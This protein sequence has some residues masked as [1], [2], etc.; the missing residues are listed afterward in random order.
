VER[1][2]SSNKEVVDIAIASVN[3]KFHFSEK[4]KKRKSERGMTGQTGLSLFW[5]DPIFLLLTPCFTFLILNERIKEDFLEN[6]KLNK[7]LM[8]YREFFN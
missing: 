5:A 7:Q 8:T 4:R 2:F 1:T 3:N 6:T